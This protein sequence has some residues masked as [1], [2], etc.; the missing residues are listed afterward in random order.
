MLGLLFLQA[1]SYTG[2]PV[3]VPGK[4]ILLPSETGVSEYVGVCPNSEPQ[5]CRQNAIQ[6]FAI[7]WASETG[8]SENVGA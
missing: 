8:V 5:L 7:L 3:P 6:Y 1:P 2:T 4:I